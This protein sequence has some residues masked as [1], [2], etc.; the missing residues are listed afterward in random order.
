MKRRGPG[1]I[2]DGI[3][4]LLTDGPMPPTANR[5]LR[6]ARPD[7]LRELWATHGAEVLAH[8]TQERP[9]TRPSTWW[10]AYPEH[11]RVRLNM[12]FRESEA[13]FLLRNDLL[14]PGE[15]ER[16]PAGAL[17]KQRIRGD[18]RYAW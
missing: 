15:R 6:F 16:L 7:Q 3:W 10:R 13:S 18:D 9:G 11:R 12:K 5:F 8:W 1:P 17:K 14:L 2:E 4:A